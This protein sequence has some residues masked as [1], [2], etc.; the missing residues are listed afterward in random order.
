MKTIISQRAAWIAAVFAGIAGCSLEPP[1]SRVEPGF[2][3]AT[4]IARPMMA[5]DQRSDAPEIRAGSAII[6]DAVNGNTLYEKNADRKMPV[7]STQKL[8]TAIEV[9]EEGGLD[10][11][12]T[13]SVWDE[14]QPPTKLYLRTGDRYRKRDLLA[15]MLV[16]SANDAASVLAGSGR[17]S[18]GDF[19]ANMNRKARDLGAKNSLFLNPHG[20]DFEGQYSTARD[21]AIIAYHA[22]R[23]PL[24]RYY[25]SLRDVPFNHSDGRTDLLQNTNMLVYHWPA[26]FNGLKS[27][28]TDRGGKCLVATSKYKGT[29]TIIVMLASTPEEIFRDADRLLK[30]RFKHLPHPSSKN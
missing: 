9:I 27:G 8:L 13:V 30:W 18:Y 4:H 21:T 20:L 23:D 7:A 28:Y 12:A 17:G 5:G 10:R 15:A 14:M 29:E 2:R 26:Y 24:I 16:S 3:P 22:Y 6:I 1:D 11:P 19:I 25:A